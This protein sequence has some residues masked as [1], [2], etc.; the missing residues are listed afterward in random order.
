MVGMETTGVVIAAASLKAVMM[1]SDRLKY[2]VA[3]GIA[4]MVGAAA[5]SPRTVAADCWADCDADYY[6]CVQAYEER[7]CATTRS[8]CTPLESRS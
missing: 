4:V 5:P 1:L 7:S 2:A 3:L 6:S 8:I